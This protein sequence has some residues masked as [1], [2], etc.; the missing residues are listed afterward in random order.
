[1]STCRVTA[2][3]RLVPMRADVVASWE[4]SAAAGVDVG[5]QDAPIALDDS[6]LRGQREAHPLSRVYPLLDD[7]LGQEV[8]ACGAVMA[9]A[10]AEGN[11][12]WVCGTSESLR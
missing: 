6:D 4:R 1:M 3:L 11:L 10:D 2:D 8:R 9:L 7:V 5:Q 12:L